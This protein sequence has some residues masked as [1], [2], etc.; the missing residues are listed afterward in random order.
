MG[1]KILVYSIYGTGGFDFAGI[2]SPDGSVCQLRHAHNVIMNGS[3]RVLLGMRPACMS[4]VNI[5]YGI[6]H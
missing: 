2:N 6:I 5:Y 1:T 4:I 3:Y